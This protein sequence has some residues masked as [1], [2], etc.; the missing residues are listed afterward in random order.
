M[1]DLV[2]ESDKWT[3]KTLKQLLDK[4]KEKKGKKAPNINF[5]PKKTK[6]PEK[7]DGSIELALLRSI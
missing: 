4:D 2:S 5:R 7:Y 1:L 3:L 6:N